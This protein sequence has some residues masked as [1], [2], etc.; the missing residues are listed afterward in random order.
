MTVWGRPCN[1]MLPPQGCLKA[2]CCSFQVAHGPAWQLVL[3]TCPSLA[4]SFAAAAQPVD[5]HLHMQGGETRLCTVPRA[6]TLSQLVAKLR[7][8]TG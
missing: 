6:I 1:L 4:S 2:H 8:L 3:A 5:T 7:E